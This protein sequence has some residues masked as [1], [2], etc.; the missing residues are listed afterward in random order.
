LKIS[1]PPAN[2]VNADF[3]PLEVGD[4]LRG[5][6][7][8]HIRRAEAPRPE[9]PGGQRVDWLRPQDSAEVPKYLL[10]PDGVPAYAERPAPP[11]KL[12]ASKPYLEER[13]QAG[14]WN[15]VVLL[16]ELKERNYSGG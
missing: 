11:R 13:L 8:H 12:D 3:R 16:R 5:H 1:Q 4:L 14:A 2:G 6:D 7:A 15:A 10:R 9:C